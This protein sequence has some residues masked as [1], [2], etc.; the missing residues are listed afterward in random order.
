MSPCRDIYSKN[1]F[2]YLFEYGHIYETPH[3]W[4]ER[5]EDLDLINNRNR[6]KV[7]WHEK[8]GAYGQQYWDLA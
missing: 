5:F 1:T 6:G 2:P 4:E 3:A 7:L 8:N